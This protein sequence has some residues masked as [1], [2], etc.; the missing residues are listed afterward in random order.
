M[1]DT[2]GNGGLFDTPLGQPNYHY[3][4]MEMVHKRDFLRKITNPEI[5]ECIPSYEQTFRIMKVPKV[6]CPRPYQINQH[7]VDSS[8]TMISFRIC[9]KDDLF[10]KFDEQDIRDACEHWEQFEEKF[11]ED[12]YKSFVVPQREW[13]FTSMIAEVDPQNRG[14]TAGKLHNIPL[15]DVG[16]HRVITKSTITAELANLKLVLTEQLHWVDRDMFIVVP[17]ELNN[18]LAESNFA[19]KALVGASGNSTGVDGAWSQTLMGFNVYETNL[20]LPNDDS[21][22][23]CYYIIAGHRDAFA[24]ASGI[25]RSRLVPGIDS[26][27]TTY[28]MLAVWGGAMLYPK[29]LALGYWYF[30]PTA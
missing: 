17:S 29:H 12:C 16:A 15:G 22:H 6:S 25:I 9:H 24:Y 3:K 2:A 18:V 1:T 21:G 10:L 26:C 14:N 11:L 4:I 13:V 28:K 27:S 8:S 19:N 7:T 5:T 23:P 20:L 30:E